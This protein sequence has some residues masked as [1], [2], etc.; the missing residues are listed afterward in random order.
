MARC[1]SSAMVFFALFASTD[2]RAQSLP[3]GG[4]HLPASPS[5]PAVLG[6]PPSLPQLR[7]P[8]TLLLPPRPIPEPMHVSMTTTRTPS[9]GGPGGGEFVYP[10]LGHSQI[11]T[12]LR[13]R[14]GSW[15]DAL[16]PVCNKYDPVH[17]TLDATPI[18]GDETGG[19]GGS[20]AQI[21]C[22]PPRGVIVKIEAT[23]ADNHDGSVGIIAVS[24]GDYLDPTRPVSLAPGSPAS[25]GQSHKGPA[26]QLSCP[27][28]YVA[29]GIYG[30]S[31]AFV[32][33]IGLLCV[34][35]R[36]GTQ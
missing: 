20:L 35:V 14:Q 28:P 11:M 19:P 30:R 18:T 9:F 29:G 24:C 1:R 7:R 23:Q 16:A 36:Y 15:I 10:C 13:A 8:P 5:P 22:L 25:F 17:Q 31:G 26:V 21:T 32:D 27:P 34:H 6:P 12:G 4:V 33:R 2:A 3:P